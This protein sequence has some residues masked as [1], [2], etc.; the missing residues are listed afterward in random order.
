MNLGVT[1]SVGAVL[2]VLSSCEKK[3]PEPVPPKPIPSPTIGPESDPSDP[4]A[5]VPSPLEPVPEPT[6]ATAC[7]KQRALGCELGE[8]TPEGSTCEEVCQNSK[9]SG[10]LEL[11]WDVEMLTQA[12]SCTK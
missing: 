3:Q 12:D 10:I 7:E 6:C 8:P 5:P 1:I 9:E 2:C 4:P 11:V